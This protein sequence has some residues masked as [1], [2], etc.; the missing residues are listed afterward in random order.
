MNDT[1]KHGM[2]SSCDPNGPPRPFNTFSIGF[3]PF[4]PKKSGKGMKRGRVIYRLSGPCDQRARMFAR[5]EEIVQT[6]NSG[7]NPGKKSER[8]K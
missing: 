2:I 5:A 8:L 3:F 6:L 4:V 7:W 1:P